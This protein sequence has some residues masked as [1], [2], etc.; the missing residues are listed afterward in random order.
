MTEVIMGT[1]LDTKFYSQNYA[2]EVAGEVSRA[3]Y[4]DVI[5]NKFKNNYVVRLKSNSVSGKTIL[6]RQFLDENIDTS[7]S[8]FVDDQKS[9]SFNLKIVLSDLINQIDVL[10]RN[11]VTPD[12]WDEANLINLESEFRKRFQR[13]VRF[14]AE[15]TRPIFVV[16]DGL[17]HDGNLE[18]ILIK[19]IFE[20]YLQFGKS[21][22]RVVFSDNEKNEVMNNI[23][24]NLSCTK[25][26]IELLGL[27]SSEINTIF[28]GNL[29]S[30]SADM[31]R[32]HFSGNPI[33]IYK[34]H[35]TFKLE[36]L[37][38]ETIITELPDNMFEYQFDKLSQE[39]R[40][41]VL[42][43]LIVYSNKNFSNQAICEILEINKEQ[44]LELSKHP[45][46]VNKKDLITLKYPGD[47]SRLSQKIL[48]LKDKTYRL[49]ITWTLEQKSSPDFLNLPD[50]YDAIDDYE[51]SLGMYDNPSYLEALS[52][53]QSLSVYRGITNRGMEIS[54][55][56]NQFSTWFQFALEKSVVHSQKYIDYQTEIEALLEAN[57]VE[58]AKI[59]VNQLPLLEDQ[60]IGSGLVAKYF[61][62]KNIPIDEGFSENVRE[63][64]KKIELTD[65]GDKSLELASKLM[66]I[67]VD[68]A[69]ITLKKS[70]SIT[71]DINLLD[72]LTLA[73]SAEMIFDENFD[74]KTIIKSKI[75][76]PE[77]KRDFDSIT[78]FTEDV[79]SERI[80]EKI[81]NINDLGLK[82]NML[83]AWSQHNDAGKQKFKFVQYGFNL[84]KSAMD[85]KSNMQDYLKLS[86]QLTYSD[87]EL[88]PKVVKLFEDSLEVIKSSADSAL[89]VKLLSNL[90][91]A[92][93]KY[94]LDKANDFWT[95]IV[96]YVESISDLT[97]KLECE[98]LLAQTYL[99]NFIS[100]GDVNMKNILFDL[101]AGIDQ[102]ITTILNNY[103]YQLESL[104]KC[105]Q[106]LSNFDLDYILSKISKVNSI[107]SREEL[108]QGVIKSLT[109]KKSNW[110]MI[111]D[112]QLMF[113]KMF[114]ICELI[115]YD[116]E[117]KEESQF[118]V[119][120]Y[121]SKMIGR[122]NDFILAE[123]HVICIRK[124]LENM[125]VLKF[126]IQGLT[127]SFQ[128]NE[129]VESLEKQSFHLK[130]NILSA[131]ESI[132][133]DSLR[134]Q[135]GFELAKKMYSF[136]S[137]FSESIL[138]KISLIENSNRALDSNMTMSFIVRL[139]IRAI[140]V[141][142]R[143]ENRQVLESYVASIE[144][145]ISYIG[146]IG[147]QSILYS[148]LILEISKIDSNSQ[149][150][151][152]RLTDEVLTRLNAIG[153]D[154]FSYIQHVLI[155]VAP[156][157]FVRRRYLFDTLME[158]VDNSSRDR[159]YHAVIQ[160]LMTNTNSYEPF[161]Y[162]E[163]TQFVPEVISIDQALEAL[164]KIED[165]AIV[166][167]DIDLICDSIDRIHLKRNN[168]LISTWQSALEK[169]VVNN[170]QNSFFIGHNGYSIIDR[171]KINE[172]LNKANNSAE[173][174]LDE[175]SRISNVSD[176]A[177][178]LAIVVSKTK[179]NTELKQQKKQD[180]E[181]SIQSL[182]S[183]IEQIYRY[184]DLA[185][186]F[187]DDKNFSKKMISRAYG[188]IENSEQDFPKIEK[189]LLD[190]AHQVDDEFASSLAAT[191]DLKPEYL[192]RRKRQLKEIGWK[193]QLTNKK[194]AFTLQNASNEEIVTLQGYMWKS[195][196]EILEKSV[197][198][199]NSIDKLMNY[200]NLASRLSL[201]QSYPTYRWALEN[202]VENQPLDVNR[203]YFEAIQKS[204]NLLHMI[205][206][207]SYIDETLNNNLK[208]QSDRS[209]YINK[210]ELNKATTFIA[211]VLENDNSSRIDIIDPYFSELDL[212]FIYKLINGIHNSDDVEFRFLTSKNARL[213]ST[214]SD[215]IELDEVFP[216]YWSAKVSTQE[217]PSGQIIVVTEQTT[218]SAVFH[219]RYIIRGN[220]GVQIGGSINGLG[221]DKKLSIIKLDSQQV[222][223]VISNHAHYFSNDVLYYRSKGTKLNIQ[224][225]VI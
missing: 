78:D 143:H 128:S 20:K 99:S 112:S 88:N 93:A 160:F 37:N 109:N 13:L 53:L 197:P 113:K 182:G 214:R 177:Y 181:S 40:E 144:K 141:T 74:N 7:I 195:I 18:S 34:V 154:D 178:C 165:E 199:N 17:Y 14:S 129:L 211:D 41:S 67:D 8:V 61:N 217:M 52:S 162:S 164:E 221:K 11:E 86:N 56:H 185:Q 194:Q 48:D 224:N 114:E 92:A 157:L 111:Y 192:D 105:F 35:Q 70:F 119:V 151:L 124:T 50:Y 104:G 51:N 134:R 167:S 29:N 4:F 38:N 87:N 168:E 222:S 203:Q 31:L 152:D 69:I 140:A 219:D 21:N 131:W 68:L 15:H 77:V 59:V 210:N 156:T 188:L 135:R 44:L 26:E 6:L 122:D 171:F 60:I 139:M 79:N 3:N 94:D 193:K 176:R 123:E 116:R 27:T 107:T 189:S 223:E 173:Q 190:L 32:E 163:R 90:I 57:D 201:R 63:K 115:D 136:D 170:S 49:L 54:Q 202:I 2:G 121:W 75:T 198:A 184:Q 100:I 84:I 1:I 207:K 213:F 62:K 110:R 9:D 66:Y 166:S 191:A 118:L 206:T 58:S 187:K 85:Y 137:E 102:K 65:L 218:N 39:Q 28:D 101:Y 71:D 147:E 117:I 22:I 174:F 81:D 125:S 46:L 89:Y 153:K 225:Y 10:T 150:M 215:D 146:L 95:N 216:N 172:T 196:G 47:R 83:S 30:D 132:A 159:A 175:I 73:V 126:L 23:W 97:T 120:N 106:V 76:S 64:L 80:L 186:I 108:L 33:D 205:Q 43:A 16:L 55:K 96:S 12:K 91:S 82:I 98:S 138:I 149:R 127:S 204:G 212:G 179:K 209:I 142:Q 25:A 42:L 145:M 220:E 45:F 24:E 183:A 19:N 158:N 161:G 148:E 103:A 208:V 169:I 180:I 130:D 200:V 36:E 72:K 133:D 5:K 155:Q